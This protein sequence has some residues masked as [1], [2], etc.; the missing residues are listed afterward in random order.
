MGIVYIPVKQNASR[1]FF[2]IELE[3]STYKL[4]FDW[5]DRASKWFVNIRQPDD[6]ML[7]SGIALVLGSDLLAPFHHLAVPPGGLF[8][9]D[10]T[11]KDLDAGLDDLGDRVQ[12][13]YV[14]AA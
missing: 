2:Q 7:L 10:T 14:E 4:E 11:E 12:L 6:T 13:V 1:F 8:V 5:N 9:Y 3:D